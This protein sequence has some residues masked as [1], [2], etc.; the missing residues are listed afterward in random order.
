MIERF[1]TAQIRPL[2]LNNS[3]RARRYEDNIRR[4]KVLIAEAE[5]ITERRR[6]ILEKL[7]EEQKAFLKSI[8]DK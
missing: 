6:K 8:T 1:D 7:I 3:Q 4:I 5:K 2:K